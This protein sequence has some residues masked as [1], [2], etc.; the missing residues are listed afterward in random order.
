M[1]KS[2]EQIELENCNSLSY[3]AEHYLLIK[4]S[5]GTE[6]KPNDSEIEMLKLIEQAQ[7]E[8][9]SLKLIQLRNKTKWIIVKD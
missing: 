3:F 5:D 6:R 9:G 8:G 4:N 2:K 7:K 1:K